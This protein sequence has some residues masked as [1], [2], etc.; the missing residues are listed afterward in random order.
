MKA[1]I[2]LTIRHW[3]F[4]SC[5]PILVGAFVRCLTNEETVREEKDKRD[6]EEIEELQVKQNI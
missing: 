2:S 5:R 1:E 3:C 6:G 4:G